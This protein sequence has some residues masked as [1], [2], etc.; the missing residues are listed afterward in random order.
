MA[1]AGP[2]TS[3][4]R[5]H[6][7]DRPI[8]E[9]GFSVDVLLR[10]E[11]PHAA[12]V[13][14]VPV[15]AQHVVVTWLDVY[16]RIGSMVHVLGQYVVLIERL[17]IDVNNAAADFDDV[18]RHANYALDV[19][20]RRIKWIPEN[21]DVLSLNLFDP[22]NELVDEDTFLVDQLGQHAGPFDFDGLVQ[23]NND[24]DRRA[25]GEKDVAGPSADFADHVRQWCTA[26][27]RR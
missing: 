5:S 4:Q 8:S 11:A 25:D 9:N 26:C 17:V 20:L 23:K 3:V 12:V 24:H 14:L 22:V 10:D 21:D 6:F 18:A 1:L 19:G 16:R 7:V 2:P 15:I 27:L 13:G